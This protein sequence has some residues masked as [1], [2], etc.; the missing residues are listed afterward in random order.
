VQERR[1]AQAKPD[2]QILEVFVK[3]LP[4]DKTVL[5]GDLAVTLRGDTLLRT[6]PT[7]TFTW[8]ILDQEGRPA[9]LDVFHLSQMHLYIIRD[10]LGKKIHIHPTQKKENPGEW[11]VGVNL[12]SGKTW[13]MVAQVTREGTLYHLKTPITV[14]LSDATRFTPDTA[15]E[16]V[17]DGGRV[18]V[19]LHTAPSVIRAN[20]VTRLSFSIV[21][22]VENVKKTS[23][24]VISDTIFSNLHSKT[25]WNAH[26]NSITDGVSQKAGFFAVRVPSSTDP[27]AYDVQ[28]PTSG[29][30]LIDLEMTGSEAHFYVDVTK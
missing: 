14:P 29:I 27:Y 22:A 23:P 19:E 30:W 6:Q 25:T 16:L 21:D 10:D 9:A 12:S 20:E 24:G 15:R 13:H 8:T 11:I 2:R 7:R 18:R 17:V 3:D 5:V 1:V 4:F 26:G 28:F